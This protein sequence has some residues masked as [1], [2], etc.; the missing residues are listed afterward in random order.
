[1]SDTSELN[2]GADQDEITEF[3]AE[4]IISIAFGEVSV[5]IGGDAPF[6]EI[7]SRLF[8]LVSFNRVAITLII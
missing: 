2:T 7:E 6:D 3:S 8:N 4:N 5:S 1:M